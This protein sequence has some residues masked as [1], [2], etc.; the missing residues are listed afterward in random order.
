MASTVALAIG[1]GAFMGLAVPRLAR[2]IQTGP[3]K[4]ASGSV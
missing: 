1:W 4:E 3:N 2:I